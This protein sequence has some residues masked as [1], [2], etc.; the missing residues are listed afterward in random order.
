[1]ESAKKL[2]ELIKELLRM[3]FMGVLKSVL[4]ETKYMKNVIV[5]SL[6]VV[7]GILGFSSSTLLWKRLGVAFGQVTPTPVATPTPQVPTVVTGDVSDTGGLSVI[8]NGIVNAHG[9]LTTTWFEYGTVSS[10]YSG[11]TSTQVISGTDDTTVSIGTG[12]LPV[13]TGS[14]YTFYYRIAAQNNVGISYGNEKSFNSLIHMDCPG[15]YVTGSVTDATTGN[16]IKSATISGENI[17]VFTETDGSYLWDE[18]EGYSL[19]WEIVY[20]LTASANGYLSQTKSTSLS[21][22]DCSET[23][24]FELQPICEVEKI[25]IFPRILKLKREQSSEV[26]ITL[27]GDNCV[28]EGKT[29]TAT[30]G[31]VGSKRISISSTSENVDENGE[32]RFA[33]TAKNKVG[34]ARVTFKANNL[35][36]FLT[37]KV[38]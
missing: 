14:P 6:I 20:T 13:R 17:T 36:M 1:M 37:V 34:N 16:S 10:V 23:L 8:L 25:T 30:I 9:L 38:R 2:F 33:I 12:E 32:A 24:N 31:R 7:C 35:K 26:T 18:P 28:P 21:E 29:V 22:T 27:E 3:D 4:R 5:Y 15:C 11:T 19:C